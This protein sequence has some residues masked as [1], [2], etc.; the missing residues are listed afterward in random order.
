MVSWG[1]LR[2]LPKESFE[3]IFGLKKDLFPEVIL[4]SGPKERRRGRAEKRLSKRAL[5]ESLFLLRPLKVCS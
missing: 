4:Q 2:D 1:H 5:L 3:A